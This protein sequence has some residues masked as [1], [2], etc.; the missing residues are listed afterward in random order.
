MKKVVFVILVLMNGALLLTAQ[1][2]NGITNSNSV[3]RVSEMS[4]SENAVPWVREAGLRYN[5]PI[6]ARVYKNNILFQPTG[7]LLGIFKDGKCWGYQGIGNSPVGPLFNVTIGYNSAS[8]TGFNYKLYDAT[9]NLIYDIVETVNFTDNVPVGQIQA[10]ISINISGLAAISETC[11]SLFSVYPNLVQSNFQISF[12]NIASKQ[13]SI[14]LYDLK[15]QL[16]SQIYKG[17][18]HSNQTITFDRKSSQTNGLYILK[19]QVGNE[20]YSRKIVFE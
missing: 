2:D 15:G 12:A 8:A 17:E 5:M 14:E 18:I 7:A 10:P 19:V 20:K 16:V 6:L 13:A 11:E 4:T 9:T 1:N 3:A